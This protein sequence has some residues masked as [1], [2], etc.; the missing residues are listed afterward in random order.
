MVKINNINPNTLTLQTISPEDVAVIPNITINSSFNS[1]TDRIEYFVYD[2]NNNLLSSN[3]NLTSYSPELINSSGSITNINLTPEVDAIDEGFS[4]G[5][6]KTI[7]N[8]ISPELGSEG[9]RLFISEISPSRTEV[10]LSSNTNFLFNTTNFPALIS[11]GSFNFLTSPNYEIYNQ[12]RKNVEASNYFDEFYLNFG[13]NIYIIGIN[14]LLEYNPQNNTISLLIK[15]YEPLPAQI[16]LKT[17]LSIVTRKA[18]SVAYQIEFIEEITLPDSIVRISGPNYNIPI[19]DETGPLTQYQ[20]Y[21]TITSSSLSGSFFQLINQISS[22]SPQLSVDYTNYESFIFFSSAYQRLH[23]FKEKVTAISSSQAE[24]NTLYSITGGTANSTV[25]S[26]SKIL[27]EKQIETTISSFD[28]YEYFLYYTSGTYAWPKTNTEAPYILYPPTSTQ[29]TNWYLTQSDAAIEYDLNNQNNLDYIVP[30]YLRNDINNARYLLFTSMIG[31]FF[32]EIWLYTKAITE[33][34]DANSNL[35][36]GVSKDLVGIVLESLGTKIYD[37]T[38]TLEN[39]YSAVIGLSSNGSIYPSTGSEVINNY[40]TASVSNTEDIPTINDFVKLS[41]KKIYHNLPYLLKKKGTDAGLRTLINI[42]GVPDTILQINEFGGQNQINANDYDLWYNQYNYAYKQNGN[43]WIEV[44]TTLNSNW[45]APSDNPQTLMFRFKTNGLPTSNIPYSQSLYNLGSPSIVLEYTGSGYTSAS[46]SGSTIDPYYQ[47]ANLKCDGQSI[48]LPFFDGGWWSV[49][50][51][52][53]T[54]YAANS[55]YNGYD[56]NQIGFKASQSV[57]LS[58]NATSF[59]GKG[60]ATHRNFSGSFQEIRYYTVPISE[61]VFDDY[62]MNPNSIEGNGTNQGPN[63]LAF[64]ASL[65]GELYTGSTSIHPKVSGSWATTSSFASNSNFSY[66]GS[67]VFV[68]NTQSIFLN[69]FPAGIKNR[70]LQKISSQNIVLPYSSSLANIPI[71]TTLSPFKSI[72]QN[73]PESSS[74]TPN[75]NYIEV[76]FSPQNEINNDIVAQL[77]YFNIGEYIG[78][79]RLVSSSAETYPP[80]DAL[81]NAYFEKYIDNY[82]INDYIRLIKY[83]DNS[84][85]KMVKDYT[86]VRASI[87]SGIIIKQ[88]TLERNKYPV[89]QATPNTQIAYYGSGSGN[90]AWDTPFTFQ[91]L[92]VSGAG[93]RMYEVT[94]STGGV[95]PNLNGQT[96]SL[97]TGNNIVNITQSWIGTN[98]TPSGSVPFTQSSQIE[99]FNGELSGS[100]ILV[101]DGDL[102]GDNPFLNPSTT[103]LSYTITQSLTSV[104]PNWLSNNDPPNGQIYLLFDDNLTFQDPIGPS[105][106]STGGGSNLGGSTFPPPKS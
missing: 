26:S 69:Q 83:Y 63:Q 59:F 48:Y 78:D 87:A 1:V 67:P 15:L 91:N 7:Y 95:F 75:V 34:L 3:N 8:F 68:S 55:I 30:S 11:S 5:I 13:N 51:T 105:G 31:Q 79:P 62:V 14:S 82:D 41:Y 98:I 74:Y 65:G 19:K 60:D 47:Y 76:G 88:T 45:G 6:I 89:P 53:T 46:Y 58:F 93:I 25:V 35:Y 44:P 20:D 102:N 54:I 77:G 10:R 2:F 18:D 101:T 86:P 104:V 106:G 81:R 39:I 4:T 57:T 33:K 29:A 32:D 100:L 36:E 72:Q 92:V 84:L 38:Y 22:S 50:V 17:E 94:G 64:R 73:T 12:F 85:F 37:S 90:I 97:Y 56:G 28:G 70:I 42:F 99:F 21:N 23:N 80:L 61:S 40:I 27:L 103:I 66:S 52:P 43:N 96:S 9:N 49:M 71:N 24:L 16:G